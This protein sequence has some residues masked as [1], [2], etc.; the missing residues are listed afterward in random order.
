MQRHASVDE[1]RRRALA[2]GV[3]AAHAARRMQR[4]RADAGRISRPWHHATRLPHSG[5]GRPRRTTAKLATGPTNPRLTSSNRCDD[6]GSWRQPW[7][8]GASSVCGRAYGASWSG[9][10]WGAVFRPKRGLAQGS[11]GTAHVFR[12]AVLG[13]W[14]PPSANAAR[15]RGRTLVRGGRSRVLE[16]TPARRPGHTPFAA[17]GR[18]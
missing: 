18:C 16:R 13:F 4:R 14:A 3:V 7:S 6:H 8:G 10:T 2:Y 5:Q 1:Y 9:C 12:G 11:A 17:R 15:N